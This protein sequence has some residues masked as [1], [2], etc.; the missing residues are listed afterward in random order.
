MLKPIKTYQ[1]LKRKTSKNTKADNDKTAA[2][3]TATAEKQGKTI[4]RKMGLWAEQRQRRRRRTKTTKDKD[5]DKAKSKA[6]ATTPIESAGG[7][8][9]LRIVRPI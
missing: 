6:K 8:E 9:V 1:K 5:Y 7:G 3:D 4:P 2:T